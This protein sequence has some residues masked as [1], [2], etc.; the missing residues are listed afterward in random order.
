[1]DAV[2]HRRVEVEGGRLEVFVRPAAESE[3]WV[4]ISHPTEAFGPDTVA[5]VA[6]ATGTR[7]V[8]IVPRGLGGSTPAERPEDSTLEQMVDDAEVVRAALGIARWVWLG[9]SGGSMLGQVYAQRHPAALEALILAS[10]APCFRAASRDPAC[11]LSPSFP[12]WRPALEAA[13]LFDAS[14]EG[15]GA[16]EWAL[17]D[18]VGWVLRRT[19]GRALLVSP[20]EP[21]PAMRRMMPALWRFDAR[22]WLGEVKIPTLVIAGTEDPVA[23]LEHVKKVHEGIPGSTFAAIEGARHVPLA[24]APEPTT[25]AIRT[26]LAKLA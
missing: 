4:A 21:G 2:E 9:M 5:L 25:S 7:V 16:T 6:R 11:V 22:P 13:N 17:V 8:S 3:R 14:H 12:A 26:F 19:N 20:V 24:E 23:P 1:M 18:G 15:D 10:A